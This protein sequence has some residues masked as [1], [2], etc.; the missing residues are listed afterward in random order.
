MDFKVNQ[1]GDIFLEGSGGPDAHTVVAWDGEGTFSFFKRITRRGSRILKAVLTVTFPARPH[2]QR[3]QG[4]GTA[5]RRIRPWWTNAVKL[6]KR[7]ISSNFWENRRLAW[8]KFSKEKNKKILFLWYQQRN[9]YVIHKL[10]YL[11]RLENIFKHDRY[12]PLPIAVEK[13]NPA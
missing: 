5:P 9:Q 6:K 3:V 1:C 12:L 4:P 10:A 2:E 11:C 13:A 7:S 8:G